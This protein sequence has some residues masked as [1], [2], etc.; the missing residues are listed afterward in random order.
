MMRNFPI[1]VAAATVAFLAFSA[2]EASAMN[3]GGRG[4]QPGGPNGP[5]GPAGPTGSP[6]GLGDLY[7][8]NGCDDRVDLAELTGGARGD[9]LR[10]C[11]QP[12]RSF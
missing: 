9:Y 12:N 6:G 5:S 1:L 7:V 11:G 8:H 2:G 3:L 4:G 10:R